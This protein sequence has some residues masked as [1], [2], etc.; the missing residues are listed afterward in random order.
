MELLPRA[1]FLCVDAMSFF[2]LLC[3]KGALVA[4]NLTWVVWEEGV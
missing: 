4:E 1:A 3:G 2:V